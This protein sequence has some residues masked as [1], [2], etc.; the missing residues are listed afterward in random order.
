MEALYVSP[1]AL[2]NANIARINTLALGARLPTI[3]PFR[4]YLGAGLMAYGAKNTNLFRQ[5]GDLVDKI[6]KE[7]SLL[8]FQ[9]NNRP[10][11][12]SL[13]I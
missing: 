11:L 1:S 2:V 9:L 4:E 10:N 7:R 13:S 5:A 3:H 8:T 12:N 6:L